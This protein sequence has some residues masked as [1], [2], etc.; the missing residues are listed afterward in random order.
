MHVKSDADQADRPARTLKADR[1]EATRAAL[2]EAARKLFAERGYAAVATEEIVR[3]AGVTRGALYHHFAGKKELFE[4][5]YEDVERR[6][7]EQIAASVMSSANPLEA[8]HSGAQAFLDACEDPAVQRIAL[9]DAPSVLGW[10]RWREIGLQYGF[11]LVQ[12]S[13]QAAMDAG[14]IEQQPVTPL[15]HLL[16]G[17]IDEGAMLIARAHDGGHTREQVGTSVARL[18]ETLRPRQ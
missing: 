10:E 12:A 8:L 1:S 16:L 4:A 13:V 2:V 5:V 17:A 6:L 7:I 11:G 9:L 14:L 15:S 18:L 3:A